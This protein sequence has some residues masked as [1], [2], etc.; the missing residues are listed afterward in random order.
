MSSLFND[1]V[2]DIFVDI[3]L[4]IILYLCIMNI[5]KIQELQKSKANRLCRACGEYLPYTDFYVKHTN[6]DDN[7][8]RFNS[9]CKACSNIRSVN[10]ILYQR[11]YQLFRAFGITEEHYNKL[12]IKQNQC[13]GICGKHIDEMNRRLA[14]DH[15][16]PDGK[17]RGLLCVN[18]NLGLGNF[19][20]S[21]V[22][23]R[24]AIKYLARHNL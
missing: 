13:C 6:G 11:K 21:R 18:C 17:I 24:M 5:N 1:L 8:Y 9:P 14:V 10:R 4:D 12:L 3:I 22:L 16:H 19:Q 15:H 7:S 2:M 23:L 20:D